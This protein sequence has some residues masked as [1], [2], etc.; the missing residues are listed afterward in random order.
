MCDGNNTEY[1]HS[2]YSPSHIIRVIKYKSN[3]TGWDGHVADMEK[4]SHAYEMRVGITQL[5]RRRLKLEDCVTINL[6]VNG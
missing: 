2:L 6:K 1:I 3:T 4:I 5:E